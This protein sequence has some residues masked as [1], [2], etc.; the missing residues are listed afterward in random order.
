MR[1]AS[2]GEI[3]FRGP[4]VMKGYYKNKDATQKMIDKDGWLY[5]GDIGLIDNDGFLHI[6]DRKKNIIVTSNGKNIAPS[7]IEHQLLKS[8][9]IDQIVVIGNNR[10]FLSAVIV[11]PQDVIEKWA[12]RKLLSYKSY[13]ELL[14]L[15]QV[16]TLF[17]NELHRLQQNLARYEQVKKY[18][19]ISS[20]FT[21]KDGELTPSIKIKRRVITE[22]YASEIEKLYAG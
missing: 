6:T 3:L 8:R 17:N 4:N 9:Y 16:F 18:I 13:K 11:P 10:N 7:N 2:D 12:K 21:I 5:S 14:A 15:P 22:K 1:I 20:A 19:L